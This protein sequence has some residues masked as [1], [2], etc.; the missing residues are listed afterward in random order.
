MPPLKR[1][2]DYTARERKR[3]QRAR[4][5]PSVDFAWNHSA[6]KKQHDNVRK[7]GLSLAFWESIGH[8]PEV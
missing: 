5:G 7:T 4:H 3:R 6:R 1:P 8:P 2:T